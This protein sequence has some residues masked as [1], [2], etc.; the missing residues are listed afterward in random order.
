M[1]ALVA[2]TH[3]ILHNGGIFGYPQT[4]KNPDGKLR[5]L[6]EAIPIANIIENAGGMATN[7][8]HRILSIKPASI[9]QRT[10]L[11]IGSPDQIT[12]LQNYLQ[13]DKTNV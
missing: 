6:Y 13:E 11:Y 1:G 5:L 9:H 2:D 3:N 10:S 8:T 4:Q 12:M 7:G